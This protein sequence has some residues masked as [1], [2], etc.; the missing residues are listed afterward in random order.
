[1]EAL[2]SGTPVVTADIGGAREVI[3]L[4]AAG[5]LVPREAGAVAAAVRDILA[6]PPAQDAVRAAAERFS[7]AANRDSLYAHLRD[8]ARS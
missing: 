3:A 2:A 4:P 8:I 5:R 7:W 1:M 6:D